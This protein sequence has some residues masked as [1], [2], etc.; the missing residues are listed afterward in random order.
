MYWPLAYNVWIAEEIKKVVSIPI[1]A[2]GSITSPELAERILEE[3]KGDFI[4]LGRPLLADPYFPL[5]AQ[6]G[7]PED[8]RPC[9]RCL[10]GCLD[11]GLFSG[12][13]NCTVNVAVGK[14][15]EFRITPSAKPKKVAVVGGGPAGMEA[16]TIAALRG[17][18]VTLF[19]KRKLGGM[20]LEASVPEFKADIRSLISYLATQVKKSGVKT[21]EAEATSQS[22]KD[23]NFDAVI[24]ATG[25]TPNIPDVPG[26]DKSSVITAIE[27]M[28]GAKTGKNV[29][30]VGGGL[31]GCDVALF[32]AERGKKVTIVEM[33]DE[34]ARG[35]SDSPRL[36][37]FERLSKQDVEVR[38]GVHLEEVTDSG[39]TVHDKQAVKSEIKGDTVVIA[40]GFKPNLRLFDEL[41]QLPK[42]EVYAIGDC[43]EPRMIFDAI[44][45]GHWMAYGLM[46]R[47]TSTY[48]PI[49]Q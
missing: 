16:A 11:R 28:G 21:I 31:A 33:E 23:G 6:E 48:R 7:R 20:L 27:V 24:V 14:E 17:H 19:E 15:D 46:A 5:K 42:L 30:M 1:I 8:I 45:E 38:T 26:I 2:S 49:E 18:D 9:I 35:W 37:F 12:S 25:G 34:I 43:A 10:E 32:L 40:T 44:H 3:G 29:I 47:E 41:A 13:I 36:A 4:G 39:I 22:I